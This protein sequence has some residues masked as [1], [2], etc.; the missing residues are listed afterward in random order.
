MEYVGITR[1]MQ[2]DVW[3]L[4]AAVLWLGN[5]EFSADSS[6]KV[7][8]QDGKALQ[9][10]AELLKVGCWAGL[11]RLALWW[12]AACGC[13]ASGGATMSCRCEAE[14]Q[15]CPISC[16]QCFCGVCGVCHSSRAV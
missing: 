1:A 8:V 10:A 3:S 5:V 4:V 15:S 11:T 6:D 14:L 2:A 13:R 7:S 12:L 16:V 9:Y